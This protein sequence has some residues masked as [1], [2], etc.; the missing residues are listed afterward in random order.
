[1]GRRSAFERRERDFYPTPAA[2][3]R[4]LIPWLHASGIH[5]FAEPCC[6]NGDLVRHLEAHGLR[7]VYRGDIAAGQDALALDNYGDIDAVISN[8]P[9]TRKLL[10]PLIAHF[11]RIAPT[12]LLLDQDWAGT[13][14]AV[15]Y[16]TY[17]SDILPIGRQIWISGT[18]THG[19]D[20]AAWFR[21]DAR[22]SAGPV[23]H[24]FRSAPVSPHA[25]LCGHCSAP[26]RPRRADSRYC[27]DT[28]RQRAHRGRQAAASLAVTKR[29]TA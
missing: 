25:A 22:H 11:A 27:S 15:P 13:K 18:K 20:N 2:A 19:E 8:P 28:C 3:V 21:F 6:G 12:W 26:Y 5:T 1:M 7:C 24:P 14:Q 4:P 23:F 10:H 9:W 17:C 16:L 29:D